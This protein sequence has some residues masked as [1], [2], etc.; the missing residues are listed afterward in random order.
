MNERR[1]DCRVSGAMVSDTTVRVRPG[2][3]GGLINL[4]ARGALIELRRPMAPGIH[5]DLQFTRAEARV[6]IGALVLR[7]S[8]RT[9]TALDGVTYQTALLFDEPCVL[10]RAAAAQD[11]YLVPD[12]SAAVVVLDVS[13]L[14]ASEALLSSTFAEPAK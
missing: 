5:V 2:L 3:D 12:G 9:L 6:A 10:E 11:G 14:P 13:N 1:T 4:C 7:C 8:V